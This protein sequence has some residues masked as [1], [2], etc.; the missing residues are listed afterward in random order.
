ML[1]L[2]EKAFMSGLG[3][4]AMS[5]KMGED[6]VKDLKERYKMSEE[7]GRAFLEKMQGLAKDSREKVTEMAEQE[8]KKV[9][10]KVGVVPRDD[11]EQLLKRVEELEKR[12]SSQ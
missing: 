5:Q 11:F 9:M 12:L 1:E 6:L 4:I 3:A 2:L 7:E 8:V 10:E